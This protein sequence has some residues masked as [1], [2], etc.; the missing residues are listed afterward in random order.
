MAKIWPV[1]EGKRPTAGWAWADLPISEAIA[2]FELRRDDFVSD[3]E[4]I[5]RFGLTDRDLTFTGYKYIVVE[6]ETNEARQ[7]KWTPGFYKSR[8]KPDEA[9]R[10]LL[11]H[12]VVPVVGDD[13]IVRLDWK[14]T[15]DSQGRE[16]LKITVVITPRATQKLKEGAVLDAL[17][18]LQQQLSEMKD[19][20]IPIVEYVTEAELLQDGSP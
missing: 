15:I 12:A 8:I 7:K 10:R 2:L 18:R 1:Y 5:P 9:Y 19:D 14:P 20:R 13:N 3:L 11:R 6:I 17:V 4:V 16:A